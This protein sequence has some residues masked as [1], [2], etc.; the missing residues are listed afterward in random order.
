MRPGFQNEAQP[1]HMIALLLPQVLLLDLA[2]GVDQVAATST[3]TIHTGTKRK[4]PLAFALS[5]LNYRYG[6]EAVFVIKKKKKKLCRV[7]VK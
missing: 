2:V 5:D 7:R 1:E 3:Y 6:S 4:E